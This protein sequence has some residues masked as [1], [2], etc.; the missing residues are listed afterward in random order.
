MVKRGPGRPRGLNVNVDA[1]DDLLLIRCVSKG[2]LAAAAGITTGHLADMLYRQ[3]GAS[4]ETIRKMAGRL[5]CK[6]STLAPELSGRFV[7]VRTDEELGETVS[8]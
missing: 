6:P 4:P 3:K 1:V 2:E 8:A 5:G 7:A